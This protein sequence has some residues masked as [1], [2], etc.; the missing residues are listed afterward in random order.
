MMALP[1]LTAYFSNLVTLAL[2]NVDGY[3]CGTV[4]LA[5]HGT[6]K[7]AACWGITGLSHAS[8]RRYLNNHG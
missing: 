3:I 1:K 5:L 6:G 7:T 4:P 8:T 2:V